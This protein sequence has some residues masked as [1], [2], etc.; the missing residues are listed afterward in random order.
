[1]TAQIELFAVLVAIVC[2]TGFVAPAAAGGGTAAVDASGTAVTPDGED[3]ET[4]N[5]TAT[6]DGRGGGS[7]SVAPQATESEPNDDFETAIPVSE[8]TVEGLL[9]P[10][11]DDFYRIDLTNREAI[12]VEYDQGGGRD[13]NLRLFDES[14]DRVQRTGVFRG[15]GSFVYDVESN[16]TYYLRIRNENDNSR[17]Y[18][19]NLT[20]IG[21]AENDA[22]EYNEE[23]ENAASIDEERVEGRLVGSETDFFRIDLTNREAIRVEYDQGGGRNANLR[24]FDESRNQVQSSGVFRGTGSFVYDVESN[25]T[26]YL[27]ARSTNENVR[28]YELNVSVIGAAENDAFEYN[29]EFETAPR[30]EEGFLDA[31]LVGSERDLYRVE[32]EPGDTL[33][34]RYSG[35]GRSPSLRLYDADRDQVAGTGAFRG[36][37]RLVRSVD[38][39]TYYVEVDESNER[40]REY[41]LALD[42]INASENDPF[43]PNGDISTAV[44]L[45]GRFTD[46]RIL[47][48][49]RDVFE[50][51]AVVGDT[52]E[53][54][55]SS[56][57]SPD[58]RHTGSLDVR[59]FAANGTQIGSST[60]RNSDEQLTF[61]APATQTYYVAVAPD[62]SGV[63]VPYTLEVDGTR[64]AESTLALEAG[65]AR[66]DPGET[67]AATWRVENG[68]SATS[69]VRLAIGRLPDGWTVASQ[70]A[71][72]ATWNGEARI[73]NWTSLS[74]GQS[75]T[76]TATLSVPPSANATNA[77][78]LAGLYEGDSLVGL[79]SATVRVNDT[80]GLFEE[81]IPG[82]P[83]PP[84]NPDGDDRFEDVNGDGRVNF[85]DLI[86]LLFVVLPSAS[87]GELTTAQEAAFNFDDSADGAL[88]FNDLIS[89]LFEYV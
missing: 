19:A 85:D 14:R 65:R 87:S 1:M 53:V 57:S 37:A 59:V 89:Y 60:S 8:G 64:V 12:V 52:V 9:S 6:D 54:E 28:S 73:W 66:T 45:D 68:G 82:L 32:T 80:G 3:R 78:V 30:V 20:V 10:N 61:T 27:R 56:G 5:R 41:T 24:L 77:S 18:T 17:N 76:A 40:I 88:T 23:F 25:G 81:P 4:G 70:S 22:F 71:P 46:A 38:G 2:V 79:E 7:A 74:A 86:D 31:R 55:L 39:G 44:A 72:G 47:G 62:R 69:D 48:S 11:E 36:S 75:L 63:F 43:E 26:Y 34:V 21:A 83:V 58:A 13:A 29:D 67:I 50:F 33:D 49:D 16:G 15:T 51:D 42:R 84:K 35:S